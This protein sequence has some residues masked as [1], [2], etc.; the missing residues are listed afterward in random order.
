MESCGNGLQLRKLN[1]ILRKK[2]DIA[3]NQSLNF[4]I[5]ITEKVFQHVMCMTTKYWGCRRFQMTSIINCWTCNNKTNTLKPV[6]R[7]KP[8]LSHIFYQCSH[9]AGE[10]RGQISGQPLNCYL[11][12]D[13]DNYEKLCAIK[14]R[15]S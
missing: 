7:L 14:I 9:I 5:W 6:F 3:F 8:F 13:W 11:K 2:H 1:I 15:N 12:L 10:W 4:L